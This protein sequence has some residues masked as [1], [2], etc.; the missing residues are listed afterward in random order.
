MNN[1][2]IYF[3]ITILC[4]IYIEFYRETKASDYTYQEAALYNLI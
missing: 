3:S 4:G 1:N 2:N